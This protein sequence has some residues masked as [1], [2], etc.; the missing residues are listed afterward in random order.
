VSTGAVV[1]GVSTEINLIAGIL[2]FLD[3]HPECTELVVC[4]TARAVFVTWP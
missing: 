1:F 3:T 2:V 4:R